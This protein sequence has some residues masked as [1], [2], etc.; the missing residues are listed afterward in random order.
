MNEKQR[1]NK[2]NECEDGEMV[3]CTWEEL[4]IEN[5]YD[6]FLEIRGKHMHGMRRALFGYI[7]KREYVC[8]IKQGFTTSKLMKCEQKEEILAR[9]W[10]WWQLK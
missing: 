7:W 3:G 10:A 1:K 4:S 8:G 9:I 2:W 6:F 5:I